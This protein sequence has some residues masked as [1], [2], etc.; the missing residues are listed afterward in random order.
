[1]AT[2][3]KK[4]GK[5]ITPEKKV[6]EKSSDEKIEA[7]VFVE[8]QATPTII[9][10]IEIKNWEQPQH[11][12]FNNF[13]EVSK[14]NEELKAKLEKQEDEFSN[15]FNQMQ[16]K[17]D[18]LLAIIGNIGNNNSAKKVEEEEDIAVGCRMFSGLGIVNAESKQ[19]IVFACGEKKYIPY[20][21]L[22]GFLKENIR[23]NKAL[24]AN[25]LLFFYDEKNYARFKI[26]KLVDLTEEHIIEILTT[27]DTNQ[28]IG[29]INILTNNL[30]REGV[31][32]TLKYMI[33]DMLIRDASKLKGFTY[34]NR[35]ALEKY[36]GVKFDTL[37]SN[38]NMYRFIK[39]EK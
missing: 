35:D 10:D 34:D 26:K 36:I 25:G 6:V 11:I 20:E 3:V 23:N 15:K 24:F 31:L 32:H 2:Q 1:M 33:A 7:T 38:A 16:A 17:M 21:D 8:E 18:S 9:Q 39:G 30:R 12:N 27:Q 5:A 4:T 29:K 19:T 14:E 22:K 37:I 28:M 13:E